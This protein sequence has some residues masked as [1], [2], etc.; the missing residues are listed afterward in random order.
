MQGG[1]MARRGKKKP[2]EFVLDSS[3][4]LAWFFADEA[5][6]YANDV[7]HKFASAR[8]LVPAIW[9]LEIANTIVM[10]ERRKR[11]TEAQAAR[12]L[13]YLQGLPIDVE[14]TVITF[15]WGNVL[16]LAREHQVSTYDAAYLELALRR[17]RPLAT[18]DDGLR[19]ALRAAGGI[20][21]LTE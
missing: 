13:T 11:S 9:P 8:A 17:S 19:T 18:L 10:G 4:A 12:W 16:R 5:D 15:A 20:L 14:P 2:D 21:F 7:A 3:V 1:L 6:A